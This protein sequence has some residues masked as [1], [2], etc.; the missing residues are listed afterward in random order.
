MLHTK[1][2][3]DRQ[4]LHVLTW[5]PRMFWACSGSS[6]QVLCGFTGSAMSA[7][8]KDSDLWRTSTVSPFSSMFPELLSTPATMHA[9]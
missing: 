2:P 4:G 6:V 8:G 9:Q 7:M 1:V 3:V 5:P